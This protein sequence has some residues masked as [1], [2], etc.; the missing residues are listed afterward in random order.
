MKSQW[1]GCPKRYELARLIRDADH[2]RNSYEIF[3]TFLEIASGSLRQAV[4]KFMTGEFDAAI[5]SRVCELQKQLKRPENMAHAFGVLTGALEER[6][7]DF[8][9]TVMSECELVDK[10][11]RGQCFTPRELSA[12]VARMTLGDAKPDPDYR[13]LLNEPACGGGSMLIAATEI[14]KENGFF[15]WNYWWIAQ[16][17][18]IRCVQMTYVQATLLGIPAVIVHGNSLAV[19]VR[20]AWPTL[21]AAMHP[22]RKERE[23]DPELPADMEELTRGLL[24][25]V[26][27][28]HATHVQRTLSF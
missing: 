8:L 4:H 16:D 14:L 26:L 28:P 20:S 1:F 13:I 23:R 27:D 9:G 3:G 2:S 15:P 17:I 18:D 7:Y 6:A 22:L 19:E 5:E 10:S 12:V 24:D 25:G 11:W 21:V